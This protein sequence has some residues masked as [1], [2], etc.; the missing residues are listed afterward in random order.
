[1]LTVSPPPGWRGRAVTGESR[2]RPRVARP[3]F[4]AAVEKC[5]AHKLTLPDSVFERLELAAIKRGSTPSAVAADILNRYLPRH[6]IAT[7]D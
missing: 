2:T 4:S 7:D 1:L 3:L 5:G 6:R